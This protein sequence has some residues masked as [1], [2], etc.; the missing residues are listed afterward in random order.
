MNNLGDVIKLGSFRLRFNN[1][2]E[3]EMIKQ[4]MKFHADSL[5]SMGSSHSSLTSGVDIDTPPLSPMVFR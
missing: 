5:S 4:Q 3:V 1:P 2:K